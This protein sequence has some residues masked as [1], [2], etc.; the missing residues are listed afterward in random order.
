VSEQR[1]RTAGRDVTGCPAVLPVMALGALLLAACASSE[2]APPPVPPVCPSALILQGAERTA[3]YAP[4][5]GTDPSALQHLAVVTNL[6]SACRFDQD[7]VDVDLAVDLIAERGPALAGDQVELTYFVATLAA[8]GNVL[9]KQLLTS[10]IAFEDQEQVAGVAEQL[11]Y[12]LPSVTAGQGP[13]YLIYLGFQ[14]D[15]AELEERLQPL[16]R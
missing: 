1:R 4:G 2:S 8:D 14:L 11:T 3:A 5:A 7:G 10:E 12:R 9:A 13:D 6:A 16:L 15:S